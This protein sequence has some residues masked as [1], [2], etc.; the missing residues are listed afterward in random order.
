MFA[1]SK[2]YNKDMENELPILLRDAHRD[3]E[4]KSPIDIVSD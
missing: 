4:N 2:S 3:V 1:I